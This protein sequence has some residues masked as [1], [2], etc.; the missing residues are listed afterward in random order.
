MEAER[1]GFTEPH[2]IGV[3]W[4]TRVSSEVWWRSRLRKDSE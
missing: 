3:S 2:A 4:R 1:E